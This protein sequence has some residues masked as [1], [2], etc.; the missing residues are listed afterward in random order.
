MKELIL[1]IND[2]NGL[3]NK[4]TN[5][6]LNYTFSEINYSRVGTGDIAIT[7]LGSQVVNG[8]IVRNIPLIANKKYIFDIECT[9]TARIILGTETTPESSSMILGMIFA[10]AYTNEQNPDSYHRVTLG[11][12]N[13]TLNINNTVYYTCS[14][15]KRKVP[16]VWNGTEEGV[17][18]NG[19]LATPYASAV[20]TTNIRP[21]SIPSGWSGGNTFFTGFYLNVIE[22]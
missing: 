4:I 18:I 15:Y 22:V 16:I 9:L 10:N 20:L 19:Y 21:P 11:Y 5:R 6:Y 2:T 13:P 7:V 8:N 3:V 12:V 1:N 14:F 17:R